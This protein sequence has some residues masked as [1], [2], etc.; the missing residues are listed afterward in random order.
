MY[1]SKFIKITNF[2]GLQNT[3]KGTWNTESIIYYS[4][5]LKLIYLSSG[6]QSE[7]TAKAIVLSGKEWLLC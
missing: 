1:I 6:Q 4:F 5:L 2:P 7:W 3:R